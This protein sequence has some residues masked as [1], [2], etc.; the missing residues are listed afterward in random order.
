MGFPYL[1]YYHLYIYLLLLVYLSLWFQILKDRRA[2]GPIF[3]LFL[4]VV[5]KTVVL[6]SVFCLMIV[7]TGDAGSRKFPPLGLSGFG[8]G[9]GSG[10]GAGTIPSPSRIMS[11]GRCGPPWFLKSWVLF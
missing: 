4:I 5:S 6:P 1:P 9:V 8:V 3:F 2:N 10:V 11:I 7:V